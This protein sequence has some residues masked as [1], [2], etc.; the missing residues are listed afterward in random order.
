MVITDEIKFPRHIRID[1]FKA[2]EEV[3]R[4]EFIVPVKRIGEFRQQWQQ[5]RREAGKREE[6]KKSHELPGGAKR[7]RELVDQV[8]RN[9]ANHGILLHLL[10]IK[11]EEGY[12]LD[13]YDCTDDRVSAVVHDIVIDL[14]DLPLLLHKLEQEVGLLID[15]VS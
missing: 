10:L 12:T 13:V 5:S 1:P 15:T 14:D 7:V 11:D 3:P 2:K 8:N 4:T 9:L 6:R